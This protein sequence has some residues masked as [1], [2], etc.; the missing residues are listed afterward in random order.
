MGLYP[1]G[2]KECAQDIRI[3][4]GNTKIN[5]IT[6]K[7]GNNLIKILED[8]AKITRMQKFNSLLAGLAVFISI[9]SLVKDFYP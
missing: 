9:V 7:F 6:E 2:S 5:K 8:N 1:T 4:I 3:S